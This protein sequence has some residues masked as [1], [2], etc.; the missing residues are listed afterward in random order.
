MVM[1][2]HEQYQ[3]R[4]PQWEKVNDV[5]AGEDA[6]KARGT[7]YLPELAHQKDDDDEAGYASYKLRAQF[8]SAAKRTMQ[9]LVGSVMRLPAAMEGLEDSLKQQVIAKAGREG[10]SLHHVS[11]SLLRILTTSGRCAVM[12]DKS[13]DDPEARPYILTIPAEQVVFWVEGDVGGGQ[14][15]PTLIA[16]EEGY[17]VPEADDPIG[18]KTKTKPQLRLLRL[19]IPDDATRAFAGEGEGQDNSGGGFGGAPVDAL[20]YWQEIWRRSMDLPGTV[21]GG[22]VDGLIRVDVIVPVKDGGRFWEQIP[23]D[24]VN[25]VGGITLE[26]EEP[27]MLDLAN[28]LL[29]WYRNSA[30]LEHG[31]HLTG[32]PQ[33]VVV[34]F[35]IKEGEKLVIGCNYAW[36]SEETGAS[37]SYLEFSGAGLGHIAD[38]MKEKERQAALIAGRML[39][40]A[41]AEAEAFGT[42]K[43]R[44]AGS[45]SVLSTIS[46]NASEVM[47][48]AIRRWAQW[49]QP[50]YDGELGDAIS[51]VLPTDFD[52]GLLEPGRLTELF[53]ALQKGAMSWETYVFNLVRG[54]VLPPDVDA[55]EERKRIQEGAPGRTR[56]RDILVMQADVGAGRLSLETY[57]ERLVEM[58]VYD[59]LDVQAELD[60][61]ASESLEAQNRRFVAQAEF[62][63]AQRPSDGAEPP[64]EDGAEPEPEPQPEPEVGGE[65][66][67]EPEPAG[68]AAE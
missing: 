39:E 38:G 42:V 41:P 13:R 32:I 17:E 10:E 44:Q 50:S 20:I 4:A 48:R 35:Q 29:G 6:V 43:L 33:P 14:V 25:A 30:D 19:G 2:Q 11:S 65:T 57:L 15:G 51:Y 58:G 31:R 23:C 34:G 53:M 21:S 22:G 49:Q 67:E 5:V 7:I 56:E 37:A 1:I 12:V 45:R 46:D 24:V 16:I 18:N 9:G 55:E 66:E 59:N 47:G 62:I 63:K 52:A 36:V 68:A 61:M 64:A 40:T 8:F 28:V 27:A 60:R 54:E 3:Q 26:T